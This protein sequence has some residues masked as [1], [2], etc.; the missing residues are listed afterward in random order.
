[1]DTVRV[2][3]EVGRLK[4]VLV[5]RPGPETR[6][7][8]HGEFALAFPLR[9]TSSDF[10]LARAQ[11]E[12]D[13]LTAI[14]RAEGAE[15][16]EL[17]ELVGETLALAPEAKD[18]LLER[19]LA[20][21]RIEGSE[22]TEAATRYMSEAADAEQFVTRLFNGIRYGDTDLDA[23]DRFP[24]AA[25]TDS[26]FDPDTFLSSPLNTAFFTR[27]PLSVIG[28]GISL[29]HMYWHDRN[30]EVDLLQT[31]AEHHPCF[32]D[33]PQWFGHDSSFHLEGGDIVNLSGHAVAIGL[34]KSHGEPGHRPS[35]SGAAVGRRVVCHRCVRDRSAP[36]RQ[37]PAS[38]TPT[39]LPSTGTPLWWIPSWPAS[40]AST[41][42]GGPGGG[43]GVRIEPCSEG[44]ARILEAATGGGP[45]RL[46]DFGDGGG[47][48]AFEY[49][50]G[51]AGILPLAPG[52]SAC[53]R[54]ISP[55]TRRS[56]MR[57]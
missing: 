8:P 20:N 10:D 45:V 43:A 16:V 27:D 5:H 21:C 17:T 1:M 30:R 11:D 44:L 25:L 33:T 34:S 47:P 39:S 40:P 22:L 31:V 29:N 35:E 49:G 24:L 46:I 13:A 28:G 6:R 55:P 12:H 4:R 54:R 38:G 50:N 57:A 18:E 48:M 23:S 36:E 37:P 14:L 53:A 15:V 3:N 7:F 32:A 41:A 26:A 42:C 2:N 52:T 19:F 51:A 56:S 9:P